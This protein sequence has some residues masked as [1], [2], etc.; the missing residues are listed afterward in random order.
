M[1]KE[2]W[3]MFAKFPRKHCKK[4]EK[5]WEDKTAR[6][7]GGDSSHENFPQKSQTKFVWVVPGK[8]IICHRMRIVLPKVSN[9]I[10]LGVLRDKLYDITWVSSPKSLKQNLFWIFGKKTYDIT[11]GLTPKKSRT[12]FVWEFFG[13]NLMWCRWMRRRKTSEQILFE[14]L[15]GAN[16]MWIVASKRPLNNSFP[17]YFGDIPLDFLKSLQRF[18]EISLVF[19]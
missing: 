16:L 19:H 9:K 18:L 10:C 7:L 12:K 8:K 11:W 6:I 4:Y 14:M 15:G 3:K 1:P 2:N 5:I 17:N 13:A